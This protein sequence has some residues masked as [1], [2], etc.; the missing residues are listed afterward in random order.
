MYCLSRYG[1]YFDSKCL[2]CKG[3]GKYQVACQKCQ[4]RGLVQEK[5]E[6]LL[7]I[8][9]GAQEGHTVVLPGAGNKLEKSRPAED[10]YLK[11][12]AKKHE[13]F[14]RQVRITD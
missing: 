14:S 6:T 8:P 12:E 11:L 13:I 7:K 2:Q 5:I 4:V 9:A 1:S 3:K 10:F